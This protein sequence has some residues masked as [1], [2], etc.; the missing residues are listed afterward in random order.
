MSLKWISLRLV[1]RVKC[2]HLKCRCDIFPP[3][4]FT[5]ALGYCSIW[6]MFKNSDIINFTGL[7]QRVCGS[8]HNCGHAH[9][10][11]HYWGRLIFAVRQLG[12]HFLLFNSK[13]QPNQDDYPT[14]MIIS[15]CNLYKVNL[16]LWR[17]DILKSVLH[18][19]ELL[20]T[21]LMSMINKI[22]SY[23]MWLRTTQQ[24]WRVQSL[25]A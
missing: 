11:S 16:S 13:I 8:K 22:P 3:W 1:H 2:C 20:M 12:N 10:W 17:E 18:I 9:I 7:K 6:T 19:P 21:L 5:W 24:I 15:R 25:Y 14:K 23:S 4:F